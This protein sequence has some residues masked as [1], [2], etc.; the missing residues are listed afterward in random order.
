MQPSNPAL[1]STANTSPSDRPP[2]ASLTALYS[3]RTAPSSSRGRMC[4]RSIENRR[5][6]STSPMY[7]EISFRYSSA[8]SVAPV[9]TATFTFASA[10]RSSGD[11]FES[12]C[13]SVIRSRGRCS[14]WR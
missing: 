2:A 10:L 13:P 6:R 1:K 12:I 9:F 5:G 8:I 4:R 3:S 7:G 11:R 14:V